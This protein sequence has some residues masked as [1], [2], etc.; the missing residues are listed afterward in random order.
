MKVIA[1]ICLTLMSVAKD[2]IS[3]LLVLDPS[4]RLTS[5]ELIEHS[6]FK[7]WTS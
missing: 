2:L 5:E 7:K 6:W 4:G 1:S 3:N